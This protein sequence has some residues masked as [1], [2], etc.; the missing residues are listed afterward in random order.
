MRSSARVP[1]LL[2]VVALVAGACSG[3]DDKRDAAAATCAW[4]I[5]VTA[6]EGGV[7]GLAPDALGASIAMSE[8]NEARPRCKFE[9]Q[10][11]ATSSDASALAN[12]ETAVACVCSFPAS[13]ALGAARSLAKASIVT[14][15]VSARA[16]VTGRV[17]NAW[18][19]AVADYSVE[20]QAAAEYIR[21]SLD[22]SAIAIAH[23]GSRYGKALVRGVTESLGELAG[24]P[25]RVT[26]GETSS[27]TAAIASQA[28]DLVY[29][30][31]ASG[32]AGALANSLNKEG[33]KVLVLAGSD[34]MG[35]DFIE[36]A[37]SA[38]ESA[39]ATCACVD[40]TKV[41]AARDFVSAYK[42]R[43]DTVPPRYSVEGY[44]MA[45]IVIRSLR[46]ANGGSSTEELR[47]AVVEAFGSDRPIPGAGKTYAWDDD[48]VLQGD[49]G[50]DIW[51]YGWSVDEGAFVSLGPVADLLPG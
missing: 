7:N 18:F 19:R 17:P 49:P 45:S 14:A 26:M 33:L 25:V 2:V 23:D 10:P 40:P 46:E 43:F 11:V 42:K 4:T 30:G 27:A 31:G 36:Q 39:T 28:P 21:Q 5:G 8:A 15:D 32:T 37:G 3:G 51:V 35:D 47:G 44:D 22:P 16:P 20:A 41:A 48:G 29:F 34:S 12:D 6:Q 50:R 9:F 38:A 13:E 1:N 24:D